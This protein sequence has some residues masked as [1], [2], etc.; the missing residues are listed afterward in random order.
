M[1]TN[2][3]ER[4]ASVKITAAILELINGLKKR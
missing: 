1:G 3:V 2:N 4:E